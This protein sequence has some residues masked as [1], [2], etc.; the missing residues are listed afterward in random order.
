MKDGSDISGAPDQSNSVRNTA[1]PPKLVET[2]LHLVKKDQTEW[3]L[4]CHDFKLLRDGLLTRPGRFLPPTCCWQTRVLNILVA[5][6]NR[7]DLICFIKSFPTQ[8]HKHRRLHFLSSSEFY[9][10]GWG[11]IFRSLRM[12]LRRA[13]WVREK[14]IFRSNIVLE[15]SCFQNKSS[16]ELFFSLLRDLSQN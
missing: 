6:N 12:T 16:S 8:F 5:S 9:V 1:I 11:G 2:M 7:F 3:P 14:Y 15:H 13:P 4:L 10:L